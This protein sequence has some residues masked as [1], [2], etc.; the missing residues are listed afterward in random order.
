ME[1]GRAHFES[2][3]GVSKEDM[4]ILFSG[5]RRFLALYTLAA[6]QSHPDIPSTAFIHLLCVDNGM[7][8]FLDLPAQRFRIVGLGSKF[9]HLDSGSPLRCARNDG[10][11]GPVGGKDLI[12]EFEDRIQD[13]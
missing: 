12:I 1:N 7:Q 8:R 6:T 2:G 13:P 3:A 9:G 5:G 11:L 4:A 10:S